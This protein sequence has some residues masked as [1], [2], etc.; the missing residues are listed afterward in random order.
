MTDPETSADFD[1]RPTLN[2]NIDTDAIEESAR[3]MLTAFGEDPEREGL[4]N[5]PKRVARMYP[6]LLS[7]YRVDEKKL[8]NGAIF[9]VTY[10]DMVIVRDIEYF[11]LCEHHM[12]PFMGRAHVA[13][14]PRGQVIGLSK[15]PRIVDMFARRLQVQERMTRQIA[16]FI[17]DLLK[18]QGV[19]VVVEGLHLCAMMRGVKKIDARMTTSAMLGLF[20]RSINTRQEF[21]EHLSRGAEPLRI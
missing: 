17:H 14:I 5:T 4:V 20:R 15:I 18:P 6:E 7:G 9:N 10:D 21:L 8:V 3:A 2:E 16:D 13:Y 12:L 1:E 11:S 19:A